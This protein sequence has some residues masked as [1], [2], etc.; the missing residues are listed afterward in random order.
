[1]RT[2][3]EAGVWAIAELAE[4]IAVAA[5]ML[6]DLIRWLMNLFCLMKLRA[7]N[8]AKMHGASVNRTTIRCQRAANATVL[9]R[10]WI[11]DEKFQAFAIHR[12]IVVSITRSYRS[13]GV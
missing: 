8:Q 5:T 11:A 10:A 2:V 12:P 13:N 7:F 3:S 9:R 6:S 4:M 1:M